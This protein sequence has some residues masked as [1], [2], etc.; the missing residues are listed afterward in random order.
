MAVM[1]DVHDRIQIS[2]TRLQ[3]WAMAASGVVGVGVRCGMDS[4]LG[5]PIGI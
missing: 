1:Y 3:H 2:D 4:G 5:A